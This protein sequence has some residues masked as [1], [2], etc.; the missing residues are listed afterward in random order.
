M[1]YVIILVG[2]YGVNTSFDPIPG[3]GQQATGR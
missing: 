2:D 1:I 3:A